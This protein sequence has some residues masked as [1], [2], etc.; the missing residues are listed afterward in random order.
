VGESIFIS[1]GFKPLSRDDFVCGLS[2]AREV[3]VFVTLGVGRLTTNATR[4]VKTASNTECRYK[5]WKHRGLLEIFF[6]PFLRGT[7]VLLSG[8]DFSQENTVG[9]AACLTL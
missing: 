7:W 1:A 4:V 2:N 5:R 9:A 8:F 6:L 3:G